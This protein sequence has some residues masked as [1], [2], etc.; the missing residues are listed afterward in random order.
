MLT[1]RPQQIAA[2]EADVV[3]RFEKKSRR[4]FR[5]E[6]PEETRTMSDADCNEVVRR[7]VERGKRYGVT[8]ERDVLLFADLMLLKGR[9]F[10]Q[11]A[12]LA[13][14]KKILLKTDMDGQT[15]M[16]TIYLRLAALEDR[17]PV[18]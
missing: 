9:N 18:S 14:V 15:K 2:L 6:F 3:R 10:D 8:T 4:H 17:K 11:D 13:W 1:I 5:E 16:R 12:S 7:A